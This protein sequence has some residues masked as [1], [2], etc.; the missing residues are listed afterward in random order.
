MKYN[1]DNYILVLSKDNDYA[2]IIL[3]LIIL[4]EMKYEV[5]VD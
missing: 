1:I 4:K 2:I 5:I 3:L